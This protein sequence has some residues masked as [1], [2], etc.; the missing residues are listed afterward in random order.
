MRL[1]LIRH[2][3]T[4]SNLIGALDTL[5]PGPAL[6]ELGRQQADQLAA[7][8]APERID[9]VVASTARRTQDTAAPLVAARGLPLRT[10]Q[11]LLEIAAGDI[12][13]ASD[14]GSIARYIGVIQ[15]W[16][17]GDLA[18][19]VPGGESGEEFLA[20]YDAAIAT[21]RSGAGE[22]AAVFTHGGAMWAWVLCRAAGAA[23]TVPA[24]PGVDNTEI[25]AVEG[26]VRDGWCFLERRRPAASAATPSIPSVL[27]RVAA[28]AGPSSMGL[29]DAPPVDIAGPTPTP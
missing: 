19:R 3:A 6:A 5:P 18:A 9:E 24:V 16:V 12:E 10:H 23:P 8:V 13:M 28:S 21:L 7:S 15:N 17:A 20:R 25:L 27:G 26:S 22:T 29:A 4:A 2:A 11:G 14:V 1:L